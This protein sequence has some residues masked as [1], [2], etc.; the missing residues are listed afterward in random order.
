MRFRSTGLGKTELEAQPTG[1]ETVS[2]LLIL[3]VK[4]T[5]PVRWHIRAAIQRGDLLKLLR[6]AFTPKVIIYLLGSF[7]PR[8]P[9]E[10]ENF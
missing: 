10:P 1:L 7:I 4:T 2:D 8:K 9:V 6:L 5:K 3:H